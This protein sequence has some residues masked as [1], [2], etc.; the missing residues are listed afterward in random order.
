MRNLGGVMRQ[1]GI[2]DLDQRVRIVQIERIA[3]EEGNL[4]E[5]KETERCTSW[6]K[7]TPI[8]SR[9]SKDFSEI[10]NEVT[11]RVIVRFREDIVPTDRV[12]WRDKVLILTAPAYDADS[13]RKWTVL[14]CKELIEEQ[15]TLDEEEQI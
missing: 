7:V 8:A 2:E 4:V 12:T 10:D 11:Y 14:D 6:A 9:I 13:A 15:V 1:T 3:D 5:T